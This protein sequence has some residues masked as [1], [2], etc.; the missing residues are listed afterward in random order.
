MKVYLTPN[1]GAV[2]PLVHNILY[3]YFTH[4]L[5]CLYRQKVILGFHHLY[6]I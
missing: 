2:T 5:K 1:Y 3:G 4:R 6:D